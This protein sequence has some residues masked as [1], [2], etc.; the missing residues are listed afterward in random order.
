MSVNVSPSKVA[1]VAALPPSSRSEGRLALVAKN[2]NGRSSIDRIAESG[3]LRVR[4]PRIT[5]EDR[6]EAVL[7]NT[8]GGIVGGDNLQFEIEVAADTSIALTSQAAEKIYRSAGDI[9]RIKVRLKAHKGARLA[10]LPQETILFDRVKVKRSLEADISSTANV[11]ICES[12]V[13]G[14]TA[15]GERVSMG[16]LEDCWRIRRDGKLIFADTLRLNGKIDHLLG[17]PAV[18]NGASCIAT[19]L[20]IAPEAEVHVEAARLSLNVP[21]IEAGVSAF[22]KMLVIR[23]LTQDSFTLRRGILNVLHAIGSPPPRAFSL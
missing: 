3:P 1:A 8:A 2:S 7:I 13:F 17:R 16:A 5:E 14:R 20:H 10:W 19:V 11:T 23:L 9:S 4:F 15:M 18:A 12:I 6:L 22:E 21:D